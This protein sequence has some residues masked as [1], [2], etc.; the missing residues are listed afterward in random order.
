MRKGA[1]PPA[2]LEVA[3]PW[4]QR[5]RGFR[6]LRAILEDEVLREARIPAPPAEP[7]PHDVELLERVRRQLPESFQLF[8][9]Q[10]SFG[11]PFRRAILD[12]LYDISEGW[13]GAAFEF[14]DPVLEQ[15][16]VELLR[17]VGEL[18][19][20]T[21]AR[22]YSMRSN[23]AL[24]SPKTDRD[25]A[26]GT[27]PSTVAAVIAM[28]AKASELSAV[29]DLFERTARDRIRVAARPAPEAGDAAGHAATAIPAVTGSEP[30]EGQDDQSQ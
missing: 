27:Q 12:P 21:L 6:A 2:K 20:L 11:E 9:R 5:N 4:R 13:R 10:H 1:P 23:D 26:E 3:P 15:P 14:H 22:L 30:V 18:T 8:L 24:L 17:L 28:N 19:D 7:H 25:R 29:I 16:F